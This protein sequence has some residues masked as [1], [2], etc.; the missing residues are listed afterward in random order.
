MKI[1]QKR[2]K[3][4]GKGLKKV[5]QFRDTHI[6]PSFAKDVLLKED[7][8]LA[9]NL[10]NGTKFQQLESP[11]YTLDKLINFAAEFFKDR[12]S[13][14]HINVTLGMNKNFENLKDLQ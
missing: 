1:F 7:L 4:Y 2:H 9:A 8:D 5:K 3:P 11:C 13:I 10:F 6:N 14:F 12:F